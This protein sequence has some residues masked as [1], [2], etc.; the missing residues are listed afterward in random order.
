MEPYGYSDSQQTPTWCL[1]VIISPLLLN[2]SWHSWCPEHWSLMAERQPPVS[3]CGKTSFLN[4][5]GPAATT[6]S[7]PACLSKTANHY[8]SEAKCTIHDTQ[9]RRGRQQRSYSP[10]A[11]QHW[12]AS[13][14]NDTQF[15]LCIENRVRK[16]FVDDNKL[17]KLKI[18][19]YS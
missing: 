3:A 4:S 2:A 13:V 18:H 11:P 9:S 17:P 14:I 16:G 8:L 10:S 19:P 7:E 1:S 12:D 5:T 6:P 15:L